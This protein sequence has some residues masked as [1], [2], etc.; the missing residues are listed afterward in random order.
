MEAYGEEMHSSA[1]WKDCRDQ[2]Q[3]RVNTGSEFSV[4][5]DET[6]IGALDSRRL[7]S[8]AGPDLVRLGVWIGAT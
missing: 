5:G 4:E 6:L 1:W 2:E 8:R 3:A 7:W